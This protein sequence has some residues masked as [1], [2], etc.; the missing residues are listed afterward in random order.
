MAAIG[1]CA[2]AAPGNRL[3]SVPA[4]QRDQLAPG[5]DLVGIGVLASRESDLARAL[6]LL[7]A[8]HAREQE[9]EPLQEGARVLVGLRREHGEPPVSDASY[10]V[11]FAAGEREH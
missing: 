6:Q 10:R 3:F 1:D 8:F 2:P 9:I 4:N 11:L 5:G 7:N